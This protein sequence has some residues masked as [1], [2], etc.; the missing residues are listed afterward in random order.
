MLRWISKGLELI[1]LLI[2]AQALVVGLMATQNA[3]FK[4]IRLLFIGSLVFFAGYMIEYLW[5]PS[6]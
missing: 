1:G 4:E 5:G 6:E 3:M 2:V